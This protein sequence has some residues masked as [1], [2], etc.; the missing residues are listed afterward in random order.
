[1]I[2]KKFTN[3]FKKKSKFFSKI[4]LKL[5][6][7]KKTIYSQIWINDLQTVIMC[8]SIGTNQNLSESKKNFYHEILSFISEITSW[9]V[10]LKKVWG[11]TLTTD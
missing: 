4:I 7:E 11:K 2:L 3:V 5:F 10:Q 9:N 1:M 6:A 8:W